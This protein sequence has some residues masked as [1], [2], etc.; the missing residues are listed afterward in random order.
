MIQNCNVVKIP[1]SRSNCAVLPSLVKGMITLPANF[2]ATAA[3]IIDPTFWQALL[4]VVGITRGYLWPDFFNFENKSEAAVYAQNALATK[5]VRPGRYQF[6]ASISKDLCTHKAI[7]THKAGAGQVA[8][9]DVDN[10]VW[11]WLSDDDGLYRGLS[12][13]LIN[14]EKLT[15]N[16]GTNPTTSPIYIVLSDSNELDKHG[17]MV[18]GD[19]VSTLTP[20]SVADMTQVGALTSTVIVVDVAAD[21][22][23]TAIS[24]LLAADFSYKT[25]AGAPVAFTGV[26]ES[27]TLPGRYTLTAAAGLLTLGTVTLR[28]PNTLT[29]KLYEIAPI[30]V[31]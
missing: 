2:S 23:G 19:F 9:V 17:Y 3:N 7:H 26:V 31:V 15:L 30:V 25:A 24:G 28:P 10:N 12:V 16:D 11:L 27:A 20:L 1:I 8:F 4:G 21:C 22:D 5:N 14:P 18:Q 29:V 13:Q 6:L